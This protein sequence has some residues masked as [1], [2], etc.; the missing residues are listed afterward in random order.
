[1]TDKKLTNSN[2][3]RHFKYLWRRRSLKK[4]NHP[5]ELKAFAAHGIKTV[6]PQEIFTP[7]FHVPK[8]E[9]FIPPSETLPPP[10]PSSLHV[11]D[12]S[13]A[14]LL[15]RGLDLVQQLCWSVVA[16][17]LPDQVVARKRVV[18]EEEALL[19]QQ[20]ILSCH[21]LDAWHVRLP[22]HLNLELPNKLETFVRFGIP[23]HRKNEL[24]SERMLEVLSQTS[25][26]PLQLLT[27]PVLHHTTLSCT[28]RHSGSLVLLEL[29]CPLWVGAYSPL[30]PVVSLEETKLFVP[31]EVDDKTKRKILRKQIAAETG[32]PLQNPLPPIYPLLPFIGAK[33]MDQYEEQGDTQYVMGAP[34]VFPHTVHIHHVAPLM[35]LPSLDGE[36]RTALT[37]L[38]LYGHALS[39]AVASRA[40][41]NSA[42]HLERP[43]V[44]QGVHWD[45]HQVQTAVFQ[46]NTLGPHCRPLAP[47]L[48]HITD[49]DA[50]AGAGIRN[51][52]FAEPFQD[53]YSKCDR[54]DSGQPLLVGLNT[55]VVASVRALC[56]A[57]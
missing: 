47:H 8:L 32:G 16:D 54:D 15:A 11:V 4:I 44:V 40:Q 49:S 1:M 55:E 23:S 6:A 35:P 7:A 42:G 12:G 34:G 41:V 26:D 9:E 21:L 46:L 3:I 5:H 51:A 25:V 19:V 39:F 10:H 33:K 38:N 50:E 45:Q 56:E 24:L 43:L 18:A 28:V 14:P 17:T 36:Q 30:S 31:K 37:L 27:R 52:F 20:S 29:P 53:L 22:K 48:S 13:F 57:Q 2:L